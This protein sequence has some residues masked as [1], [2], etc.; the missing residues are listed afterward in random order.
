MCWYIIITLFNF[1]G[2]LV[3]TGHNVISTKEVRLPATVLQIKQICRIYCEH[4]SREVEKK[5]IDRKPFSLPV[6]LLVLILCIVSAFGSQIDQVGCDCWGSQNTWTYIKLDI[7]YMRKVYTNSVW[8]VLT[9]TPSGEWRIND[10]ICLY[11]VRACLYHLVR[12]IE[13]KCVWISHWRMNTGSLL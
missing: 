11:I 3:V 5:C 13:T 10:D 9:W 1:V 6:M 12:E 8:Y 7:I 4:L 2:L